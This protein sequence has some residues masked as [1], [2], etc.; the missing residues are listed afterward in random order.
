MGR[1]D[2]LLKQSLNDLAP[3]VDEAGL[4]ESLQARVTAERRE[5]RRRLALVILA[6]IVVA[7]LAFAAYETIKWYIAE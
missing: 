4:W 1:D 3:S 2:L 6:A 5:R 7:T